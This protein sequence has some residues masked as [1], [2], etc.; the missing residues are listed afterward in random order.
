MILKKGIIFFVLYLFFENAFSQVG[1]N[2]TYSYLNLPIPARTAAL[3]GSSIALKDDD[4]NMAAQ[5]PALLSEKTSNSLS[6]SY[7]NF[8]GAVNYGYVTYG[9]SFN[10]I[11]HFAL[12]IQDVGYGT[13][14]ERDEYGNLTGNTYKSNDY[15]FS[16]MYARDKD[17][18]WSW[19]VALK[20]LY[21]KYGM[22]SSVGNAV[23]FGITYHKA[24]K[25]FTVSAVLQNLGVQWKS[26][27]GGPREP[28]PFNFAVGLS[29][30]LKHAPFRF[31]LTYDYLNK[32]NLAYQLPTDTQT[33]DPFT[34]Q[35]IKQ[36]PFGKFMDKLGRH[37][38]VATEIVVTK[39]I[40]LRVGFNYKMRKELSL[41]NKQ[42]L[43]GFS[44]GLGFKVSKIQIS[45]AYTQISP[46]FSMNSITLA[47]NFGSYVKSKPAPT[48]P[49]TTP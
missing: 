45:Y 48:S 25:L 18:L 14:Q 47:T 29:K 26:Y 24:S 31:I 4:I 23:D 11:G 7:I 3:G 10:K 28:L 1:G 38:I 49:T 41:E 44:F 20:T 35:P 46:V 34:H 22:Y 30:K 36:H 39:N 8:L 13:I 6:G 21:S 9:R 27:T 19:G 16:I 37:F 2:S 17:S 33:V 12:G 5:N 40:F 42:G 32:W 43:A 15:N